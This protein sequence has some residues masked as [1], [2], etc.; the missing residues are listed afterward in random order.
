MIIWPELEDKEFMMEKVYIKRISDDGVQTLG[1]MHYD[2]KEVAKTLELP[3]RNNAQRISCIPTGTYRVIRRTSKKYG[4]HFHIL[5]VDSRS[6]ILIH[7]ANFYYQLLGCIGVGRAHI[8]I[9]GDGLRDITASR[10]TM[11]RL[12]NLLPK[13]FQLI[14]T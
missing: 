6:Y 10:A 5:G 13:E 1:T 4:R 14:I 9:N 11:T 8:D 7:H 12:L 2:D 3:W